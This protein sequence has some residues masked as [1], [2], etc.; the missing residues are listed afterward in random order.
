MW[1]HSGNGAIAAWLMNNSTSTPTQ[2]SGQSF[3]PQLPAPWKIVGTGDANKDGKTD[4]FFQNDAGANT[5]VAVWH[6]NGV[7]Q[8]DG[9]S[10]TPISGAVS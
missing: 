7:N 9:V 10:I 2:I 1:Q 5:L 4:L 3:N 8:V 6:M